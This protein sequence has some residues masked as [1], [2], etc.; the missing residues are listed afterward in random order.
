MPF[1]EKISE[2]IKESRLRK[3]SPSVK[4][5]D[6]PSK[7]DDPQ[8]MADF[9]ADVEKNKPKKEKKI[10]SP[11]ELNLKLRSLYSIPFSVNR[12]NISSYLENVTNANHRFFLKR[13]AING[14]EFDVC[15]ILQGENQ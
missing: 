14:K 1:K 9:K 11:S 12:N 7:F 2:P 4:F 13:Y 5:D 6:R 15:W 8:F 10:L 3:D